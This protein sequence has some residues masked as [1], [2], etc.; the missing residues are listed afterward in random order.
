KG[1]EYQLTDAIKS[2]V[3]NGQTV[4]AIKMDSFKK[5]LDVGTVESYKE[6]LVISFKLR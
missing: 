2:M 3:K 5:D 4:L 1:G 6:S